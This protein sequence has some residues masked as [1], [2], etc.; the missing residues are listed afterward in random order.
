MITEKI[1]DNSE[2]KA[3]LWRETRKLDNMIK[4]MGFTYI[5]FYNGEKGFLVGQEKR[6][7]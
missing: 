1:R 5:H 4:E 2:Q 3:C 7:W 6:R